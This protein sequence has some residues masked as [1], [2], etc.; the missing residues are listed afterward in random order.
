MDFPIMQSQLLNLFGKPRD[1]APYLKVIDLKEFAGYLGHVRDFQG[2]PWSCRIYGHEAMAGPLKA[3]FRLLCE[4]GYAGELKT[5]D[6]CVCIRPPKGGSMPYSVHAWGLAVDFNALT[7]PYGG[8][9]TLSARLV[10]YFAEC[11][12]EWG[13]LWSTPDGMHFQLP[14]VRAREDGNPLNPV[15]WRGEPGEQPVT[16]PE[17]ENTPES[18]YRVAAET[19]NIRSG[20]GTGFEDWGNISGGEIVAPVNTDGW[21]PIL[22][23]DNSIGWLAEKYLHKVR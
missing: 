17:P 19:L 18:R 14:W 22:L 13:G 15:A 3:A 21:V 5:Y 11:G 9:P 12:F 6:G 2:N 8:R 1:P 7:N 10:K 4:R 20:P 16:G 23:E